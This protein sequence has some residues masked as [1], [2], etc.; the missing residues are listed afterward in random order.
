MSPFSG[1]NT[2]TMIVTD[3]YKMDM[4]MLVA[5][6]LTFESPTSSA[7]CGVELEVDEDYIV[8]LTISEEGTL[9]AYLCGPTQKVDSITA[10]QLAVL[11]NGGSCV[12]Q[13]GDM[14]CGYDEVNI[15]LFDPHDL[16]PVRS[17]NLSR[18]VMRCGYGRSGSF[19]SKKA[20]RGCFRYFLLNLALFRSHTADSLTLRSPLSAP[21]D[22]I[23]SHPRLPDPIE[24][25][26][27][28]RP[29]ERRQECIVGLDGEMCVDKSDDGDFSYD[30]TVLMEEDPWFP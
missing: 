16:Q 12:R 7:A 5:D 18:N 21:P 17:M 1:T 2:Y 9:F 22:P 13:C 26:P 24:T 25:N 23:P 6:E 15:P 19:S 27:E 20:A 30:Y 28:P 3:I 14:V 4:D 11:E 8:G 29:L 10:E